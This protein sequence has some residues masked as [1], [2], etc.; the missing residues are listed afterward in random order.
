M[1]EGVAGVISNVLDNAP[2]GK[3]GSF[4]Y[5]AFV[6][7]KTKIK[8]AVTGSEDYSKAFI[9]AAVNKNLE[10]KYEDSI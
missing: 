4:V 7:D 5:R 6:D 3:A 1:P 10:V 9:V 2:N 8:V